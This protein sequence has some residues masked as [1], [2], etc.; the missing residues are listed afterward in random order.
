MVASRVAVAATR[1]N[2]ELILKIMSLVVGCFVLGEL[3]LVPLACLCLE[4]EK[5]SRSIRYQLLQAAGLA[6]EQ[7]Q[8]GH[9]GP[10]MARYLVQL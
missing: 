5:V 7:Q 8:H 10:D 9:R 2:R 3:W 6:V 1:K 4:I